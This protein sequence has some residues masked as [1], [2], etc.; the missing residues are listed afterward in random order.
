MTMKWPESLIPDPMR[1]VM[2]IPKDPPPSDQSNSPMDK[3][4]NGPAELR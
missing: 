4:P 1:A 2:Q 3:S